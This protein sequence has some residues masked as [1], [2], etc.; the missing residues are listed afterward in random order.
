MANWTFYKPKFEYQ[1]T[2]GEFLD[3]FGW[4]GHT[5]LA[6]DLISNTK[7]G[8]VVELG[9]HWG[10]SFFSFCQAVKDHSLPTELYAIDTWQGEKHAGFYDERVINK[11]EEIKKK[12]FNAL[13]IKLLRKTFDEALADFTN[14]SIDMLHIDGL[15]TY[16]A[17]KHDFE[18]WLPKL[19]K[20]GLV[21]FH[22]T[23]DTVRDFGVH[24][25]WHELTKKYPH[26][27]QLSHSHGLGLLCFNEKVWT[28]IEHLQAVW[29]AYYDLSFKKE[30]LGKDLFRKN[31]ELIDTRFELTGLNRQLTEE[32]KKNQQLE[33]SLEDT[34]R[35]ADNLQAI[36]DDIRNSKAYR[37]AHGLGKLHRTFKKKP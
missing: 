8:V 30:T 16:E 20:N 27:I 12:H 7:P 28:D 19:K 15:H 11:V 37:L 18:S 33:T 21:L 9:T 1:D 23:S 32:L 34:A 6:Y 3:T 22:D 31:R 10:V 36:L 13:K 17:V 5:Y 24:K 4:L 25:F 29:E 26:T 2:L 35:H 14:N